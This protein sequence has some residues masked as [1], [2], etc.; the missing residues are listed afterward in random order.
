LIRNALSREFARRGGE[1]REPDRHATALSRIGRNLGW[2][3][4]SRGFAGLVSIAYMALAAR[5][6]GPAGFGIFALILTYGQLI[7]NLVQ[8]QSWK[9]VIR[10]GAIHMTEDRPDRLARLFGFSATLDIGSALVG[11]LLAI[12]TMPII[13]PLIHLTVEEQNTAAL[14]GA[15]LL[16]TTGAT[17]TGILRLYDRFDMLA[18][19]DAI[20]PIV[21]VIGSVIGWWL[22][23]DVRWFL[24][25][26]A[27][28]AILQAAGQWF[29]ALVL[30]RA[31]LKIG[32][33]AFRQTLQENR[34][35]W[36]FMLMT[37]LSSSL[38]LFWLQ[39]GT[40]AVG[41]WA[42]PVEAGGFRIAHR[43]ARAI[44]KP[45]ETIT[46]ALYPE[47]ARLVAEDD[48][49]TLRKLLIRVCLVAALFASVVVL[50]TGLAGREILHLIAGK[51]FEFAYVFFFLLSI[52]TAIDLAGFALEPFHNAHGRAGRVL[53]CRVVGAIVY[54]ALLALLLPMF[55][56]RGAAFAAIAASL[57][58]FVQLAHS[59]LQI[60]A[61]SE[62]V[63]S[64]PADVDEDLRGSSNRFRE[65][66]E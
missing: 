24:L 29:A 25:V 62:R 58:I 49:R 37:N 48:H 39:S 53:R 42:G 4:G 31:K 38:S 6:M 16:L 15:V 14:F 8:F 1:G 32:R 36:R 47:L 21:R 5:T 12:L 65:E 63:R 54:V 56:A 34:R 22:V 43:F 26:W 61:K 2:I 11:S 7:A 13:G 27:L 50:A 66:L 60:L 9:G 45:V 35:I 3:A 46:R 44:I 23:L 51:K 64:D 19:T 33:N 55:G 41:G 18:F 40:L 10:Y 57:V 59:T 20:G 17:P 28:A 52:S 30:Q